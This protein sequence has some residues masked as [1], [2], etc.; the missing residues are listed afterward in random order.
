LG[1]IR[2]VVSIVLLLIPGGLYG[3]SADAI[4]KRL[5]AEAV[6]LESWTADK[7]LLAAVRA[8]NAQKLTMAEIER[9][10]KA[11]PGDAA[12]VRSVTTGAC[13]DRLREL[14]ATSKQY[15]EILLMDDQ[16]ALVC[17]SN[18]TSDYFQGDEPKWQR[19]YA[20]GTGAVF[21]DRPRRDDSTS[22]RLA[23]VSL[24]LRADGK[25]MGAITIGL[26]LDELAAP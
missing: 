4:Q 24:P 14:A 21:I 20:D 16:G 23:Q 19:S 2:R 25:V 7:A 22:E 10:D 8:Q 5:E 9:R 11:W 6:R 3:Q 26:R 1:S 17:A 18:P 12:L 13:A 15:G